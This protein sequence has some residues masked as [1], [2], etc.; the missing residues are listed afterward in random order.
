[1]NFDYKLIHE[2][3]LAQDVTLALDF[4][5]LELTYSNNALTS[6]SDT[7]VA[8]KNLQSFRDL[9]LIPGCLLPKNSFKNLITPE[10][11]QLERK[12]E[13]D[14]AKVSEALADL[15]DTSVNSSHSQTKRKAKQI[16]S[17]VQKCH[18]DLRV[19]G[20]RLVVSFFDD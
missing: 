4:G 10:K 7:L 19:S 6:L 14:C 15:R 1:M 18:I 3:K 16:G 20:D 5:R 13:K 11:A 8:F 9:N 2:K 12:W 17:L